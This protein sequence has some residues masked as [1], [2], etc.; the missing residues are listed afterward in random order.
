MDIARETDACSIV[1]SIIICVSK[2]FERVIFKTL[3]DRIRPYRSTISCL[4]NRLESHML[5]LFSKLRLRTCGYLPF[6]HHFGRRVRNSTAFIQIMLQK[7]A[8]ATRKVGAFE[9]QL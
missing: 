4:A 5:F 9:V 6:R 3:V 1:L 8:T 2:T 7:F